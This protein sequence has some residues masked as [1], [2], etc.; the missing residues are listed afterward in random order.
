MEN[1]LIGRDLELAVIDDFTASA[2]DARSVLL[3]AGE[4]GIG[5][6]ALWQLVVDRA[7][8]RGWHVLPARCAEGEVREA[9]A[10]LTDLLGP[11]F[12][13]VAGAI[14]SPLA[15]ALGAALLRSPGNLDGQARVVG[16]AT[17]A[18]IDALAATQHV[19]VAIDDVQ[20]LDADSER[21]IEFAAIRSAP[22]VSFALTARVDD[23][24][25]LPL[26]L[27]RTVDSRRSFRVLPRPLS[28]AGL[29]HVLSRSPGGTPPRRILTKIA[30]ASGGNPF[31]AIELG[32]AWRERRDPDAEDLVMP[33][34]VRDLV[35]RRL[36]ELTPEAQEVVLYVAAAGSPSIEL[37]Q[38]AIGPDLQQAL[39]EA[40]R[41]GV[42]LEELGRLI[43]SHPLLTAAAYAAA[44]QARRRRVHAR[45]ADA[46][47]DV[48][49]QARHLAVATT[50]VDSSAADV[51]ARGAA[52]A[53]ARGAPT[54]AADLFAA[55]VR[56]TPNDG[57]APARLLADEAVAR[58][59]AGEVAAARTLADR[60]IA[61]ASAADRAAILLQVA[62][63]AW[64]DGAIR[65]EWR[66]LNEALPEASED[67][68]LELGLRTKLVALGVAIA[69][70]EATAQA[71]SALRLV[72]VDADPSRSGQLLINR[73]MASAL[74]GRG[75]RWDAL[76]RGIDKETRGL[77]NGGAMNSPPLVLYTMTDR[78]E[79]VRRRF[80]SEDAWYAERGEE[81]WRAE[82]LGQRAL[83]EL[84]A[85][86]TAL[87][88]RLMDE[89]HATLE[90][91]GAEDAWPLVHA[92]RALIDAHLGELARARSTID[93]TLTEHA[94][95]AELWLAILEL[96]SAFVAYA[97]GDGEGVE[98]AVDR[99]QAAMGGVG[100]SDLLADRSETFLVETRLARGNVSGARDVLKRLEIR[101]AGLPRAWTAIALQ[102]NRAQLQAAE[103]D[104][105]A[106]LE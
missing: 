34:S 77:S 18:A 71:D 106:A 9:H 59:A 45:L 92:W 85:G 1:E 40:E 50:A 47:S 44:P 16:A 6:T 73:E 76:A 11:A 90:R 104:L 42:L 15:D 86:E 105:V 56:L 49:E 97:E 30:E 99:M 38:R 75:V 57:V 87:A 43:A 94:D 67:A 83:A 23:P 103:G 12:D 37:L 3:I 28:V 64:A 63:I 13:E 88:R 101:H 20:W 60:A 58:L 17:A 61:T 33:A 69:P 79:D 2:G 93:H 5:K 82:R 51:V 7:T 89:A 72:D 8:E 52:A 32:R 46:A 39:E 95:D 26:G 96:V 27:S 14:P 80:A 24:S 78:I 21:A 55:A 35:D 36:S 74:A 81:G 68:T 100:V 25:I 54:A 19:L 31:A 91:T 41:A 10:G 4:A 84:R 66:R 98:R 29:H 53:L 22:T 62:D 48:E 70:G 65:Q 102:R